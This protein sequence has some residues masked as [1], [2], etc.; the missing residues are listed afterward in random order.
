MKYYLLGVFASAVLL[1]GM[2]LLYG[3]AGST[4]LTDIGVAS[5]RAS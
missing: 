2:S 5:R 1:Y 3:A 4:K